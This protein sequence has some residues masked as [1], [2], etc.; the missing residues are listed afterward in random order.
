MAL[1]ANMGSI[2]LKSLSVLLGIFFIFVGVMKITSQVSKDLHKD[3]VR[4]FVHLMSCIRYTVLLNYTQCGCVAFPCNICNPLSRV[5]SL[6]T[7]L[8]GDP[9]M[10]ST[11]SS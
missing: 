11:M 6:T 8:T 9:I 5:V 4:I 2:V 7:I 10:P 3:L 1:P